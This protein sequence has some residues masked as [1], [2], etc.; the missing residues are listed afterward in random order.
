MA[1]PKLSVMLG[2]CASFGKFTYLALVVSLLICHPT[3]AQFTPPDQ[4]YYLRF[5]QR[6][7]SILSG[8]PFPSFPQGT[9]AWVDSAGTLELTQDFTVETWVFWEDF[10]YEEIQAASGV[11]M[12]SAFLFCGVGSFGL[13]YRTYGLP[14]WIFFV[15]TKFGNQRLEVPS[16]V[17]PRGE[18]F[19]FAATYD[20]D[21]VKIYVNGTLAG[22]AEEIGAGPLQGMGFPFDAS[23]FYQQPHLTEV[24]AIGSGE[25][26]TGGIRQMRLWNRVLSQ[27]EIAAGMSIKLEGTE[28]NLISYWPFDGPYTSYEAENL[29]AG[30]PDLE[31]GWPPPPPEPSDNRPDWLPTNPIFE[32]REDLIEDVALTG[33]N[34]AP[35]TRVIMN[36]IDLEKDEDMDL[37]YTGGVT[38]DAS[39]TGCWN[40]GSTETGVLIRNDTGRYVLGTETGIVGAPPLVHTSGLAIVADFNG[41]GIDDWF[42]GNAGT[43]FC[44]DEAGAVNTL[45]LATPA[46]LL[47]DASENL[48]GAPC[49]ELEPQFPGQNPCLFSGNALGRPPGPRYP[50]P[51]PEVPL[52]IDFSSP[53]IGD[54][55]G[56]GD[57]DVTISNAPY[58]GI[59]SSYILIN[60]GS[61]V[62]SAD[63][64]RLP[65]LYY[66]PL[67]KN[68][69]P[70]GEGVAASMGFIV[71]DLDED[72]FAD[73]FAGPSRDNMGQGE[74]ITG[75]FWGDGTGDFSESPVTVIQPPPT[76]NPGP[77]LGTSD[78]V[79]VDGDGDPD[80]VQV[81]SE[82]AEFNDMPSTLQILINHGER[83][84]IDET[85]QRAGTP[86]Q[87]GMPRNLLDYKTFMVD[88]NGD[89]CPDITFPKDSSK[90]L[91]AL[92]WV[93]DCSGHYAPV[94]ETALT[95]RLGW[96]LP[97]DYEGDGD[98][99]FIYAWVITIEMA[100][101][102]DCRP[103][104]GGGGDYIDFSILLNV[105]P[106]EIRFPAMFRDGFESQN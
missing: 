47:E 79:D 3:A 83:T 90:I 23:C 65:D 39:G 28:P 18:W 103:E 80:I 70:A 69:D 1:V 21:F 43:D 96:Y 7:G 31:L 99:D 78:V 84:F 88:V 66:G 46:G 68:G 89:D 24:F 105:R 93:N 85:E 41:D 42:S 34:S 57:I 91:D 98:M 36:L 74:W 40:S 33:C 49:S 25:G 53:F 101:N 81:W 77:I 14:G 71:E 104:E 51:G 11:D 52:P 59:E 17:M 58:H 63:W 8:V 16:L 26:F 62:F 19:H 30:G 48:L 44:D 72:G 27:A 45:M 10:D 102:S 32:V 37:I 106:E 4:D 38:S 64:E 92:V 13:M 86:P 54:V 2:E 60:N 56:D 87:E 9:I 76:G 22:Q 35:N 29:V 20:G 94:F 61:G 82:F 73:L 5:Y 50:G 12:D 15:G 6:P 75:I 100:D 67:N 55:D 95:K 97:F